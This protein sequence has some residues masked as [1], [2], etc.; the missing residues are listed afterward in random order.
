MSLVIF[1]LLVVV[2][3]ALLVW[4]VSY[5]PLPEP[6]KNLILALICIIGALLVFSKIV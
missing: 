2:G 6:A 4:G 3:V 1:A 5:L